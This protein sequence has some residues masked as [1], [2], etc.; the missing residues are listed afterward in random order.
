MPREY[1]NFSRRQIECKHSN[2]GG[3]FSVEI[4]VISKLAE[5]LCCHLAFG[6][7]LAIHWASI[8]A[9]KVGRGWL[10]SW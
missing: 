10:Q 6:K 9:G 8:N 4:K 2:F 5:E 3:E 1:L 7:A